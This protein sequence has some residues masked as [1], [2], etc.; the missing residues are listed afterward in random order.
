MAIKYCNFCDQNVEASR[1]IGVGTLLLCLCTVGLAIFLIPFYSKRCNIC[2][3]GTSFQKF[4]T[5]KE[6]GTHYE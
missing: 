3:N 5:K 1:K 4:K 2:G 6:M